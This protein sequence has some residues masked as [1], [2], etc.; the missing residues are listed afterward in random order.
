MFPSSSTV[1]NTMQR[2]NL[3]VGH[4]KSICQKIKY[5]LSSSDKPIYSLR[6]Q[7]DVKSIY[8]QTFDN[9]CDASNILFEAQICFSRIDMAEYEKL[10]AI[11]EFN[12]FGLKNEL[13]KYK[14]C[15]HGV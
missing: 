5:V 1:F 8:I 11:I 6:I 12:L 4:I 10:I 9:Y 7:E 2:I 14:F 13:I 15:L 3:L